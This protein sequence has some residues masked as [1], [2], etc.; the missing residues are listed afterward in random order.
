MEEHRYWLRSDLLILFLVICLVG[1][2]VMLYFLPS[3]SQTYLLLAP[4]VLVILVAI[5][6]LIFLYFSEFANT[7]Q[8]LSEPGIEWTITSDSAAKNTQLNPNQQIQLENSSLDEVEEYKCPHCG[9][10]ITST[11]V[12]CPMCNGTIQECAICRH[13]LKRTD[14]IR[15]CPYCDNSFHKGHLLE[16]IRVKNSCPVCRN[17]LWQDETV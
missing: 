15:K 12:L 1:L 8:M 4:I 3:N 14:E 13:S 5:G 9:T 16:W 17:E 6:G 11:D 2:P 7:R 10:D